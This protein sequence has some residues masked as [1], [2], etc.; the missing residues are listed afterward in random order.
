MTTTQ[1]AKLGP[2]IGLAL[3]AGGTATA[4]VSERGHSAVAVF[5]LFLLAIGVACALVDE[6][7][8]Q[9]GR[10]GGWHR[11]DTLGVLLLGGTGVVALAATNLV[12]VHWPI[13]ALG[14]LLAIVY[15]SLSGFY[16][17]RRRRAASTAS[18]VAVV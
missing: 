9:A 17:W 18:T 6:V 11:T 12:T 7:R 10:A 4:A 1:R 2:V 16:A 15:V 14:N 3:L 8:R 13:Q 5:T